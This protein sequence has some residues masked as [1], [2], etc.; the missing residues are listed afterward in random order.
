MPFLLSQNEGDVD[1]RIKLND[2]VTVIGRHPDCGVVIDD[3]SVSRKH[4]QVVNRNGK[5]L[6]EDLKSRNGTFLNRKMISQ[7]IRLFNGDQIRI[8]DVMFTFYQ[9]DSVDLPPPRPTME[10]PSDLASSIMLDDMTG[11]D[12]SSI[13]WGVVATILSWRV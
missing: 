2:E 11:S 1:Q 4:A 9:D 5:F 13:R 6:I 12:L 7:S 10:S 8:C 3:P